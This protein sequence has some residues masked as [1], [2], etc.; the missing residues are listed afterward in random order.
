MLLMQIGAVVWA[1]GAAGGITMAW[2][3]IAGAPHPPSWLAG[4]HGLAAVTGLVCVGWSALMRF[5]GQD[6]LQNVALGLGVLAAAGGLTLLLGFHMRARRLPVPIIIVHGILGLVTV[7]IS[8]AAAFMD[9]SL[10][11]RYPLE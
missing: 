5:E 6:V 7:G 8:L 2:L 9:T 3:R 11:S 4:L 1:L 10:G